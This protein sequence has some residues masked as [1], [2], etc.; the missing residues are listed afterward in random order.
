MKYFPLVAIETC[1]HLTAEVSPCRP[2]C[3]CARYQITCRL[4]HLQPSQRLIKEPRGLGSLWPLS[5]CHQRWAAKVVRAD[6]GG[7]RFVGQ[8]KERPRRIRELQGEPAAVSQKRD[9]GVIETSA[10]CHSRDRFISDP[11]Q[12]LQQAESWA[13]IFR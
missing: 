3:C 8:V 13:L 11:L 4:Q 2:V 10:C 6:G 5:G 12:S 1:Q 9:M 7:E